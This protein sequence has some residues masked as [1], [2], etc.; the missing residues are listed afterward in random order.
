[1]LTRESLSVIFNELG[2]TD[3]I[4]AVFTGLVPPYP[5]GVIT[6]EDLIDRLILLVDLGCRDSWI[7]REAAMVWIS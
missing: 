6:K 1:M 4:V 7:C 3:R 5:I 2:E